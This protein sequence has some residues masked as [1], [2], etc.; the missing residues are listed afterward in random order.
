[1]DERAPEY[2][3]IDETETEADVE[4][5]EDETDPEDDEEPAV[6]TVAN[7]DD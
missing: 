7:A 4:E 3:A 2:L 1:M 6:R 5:S